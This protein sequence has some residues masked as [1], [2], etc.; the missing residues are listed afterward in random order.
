MIFIILLISDQKIRISLDSINLR[1]HFLALMV[2][3]VESTLR[4]G[5]QPFTVLFVQLSLGK[6]RCDQRLFGGIVQWNLVGSA[7]GGLQHSV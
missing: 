4:M 2:Q 5:N 1:K 7:L 6:L 3:L